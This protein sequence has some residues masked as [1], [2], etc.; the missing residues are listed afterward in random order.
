MK[1]GLKTFVYLL[2]VVLLIYNVTLICRSVIYP[3]ETPSVLGIKTYVVVSGSM[4]PTLAIGDIVVVKKIEKNEL[5]EKDIISYREGQK[6]VTHRIH[7]IMLVNGDIMYRTKGDS[8]NSYDRQLIKYDDIEGKVIFV[9][10]NVG[11]FLIFLQNKNIIIL[12]I[13]IY[14]I[15]MLWQMFGKKKI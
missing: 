8:N 15:L 5:L 2:L 14:Y 6:I 10:P 1:R 11:K 9:I 7:S 4:K 3:D 12:I 13:V